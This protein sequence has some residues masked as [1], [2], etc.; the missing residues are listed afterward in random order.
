M[1]AKLSVFVISVEAIIYLLLFNL[2][3]GTFKT[4]KSFSL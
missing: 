3:D 4:A 1:N 2:H